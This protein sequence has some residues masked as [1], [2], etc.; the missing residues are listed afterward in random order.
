MLKKLTKIPIAVLEGYRW[1]KALAFVANGEN[2]RALA[3]LDKMVRKG[4]LFFEVDLLKAQI[5]NDEK[6]F[7]ECIVLCRTLIQ[8]MPEL[9]HYDVETTKYLIAYLKWLDFAN[10]DAANCESLTGSKDELFKEVIA[11]RLDEIRE[12]WKTNYPLRIHP[13]WKEVAV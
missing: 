3:V 11:V 13:N 5:L 2:H 6:R 12:R 7:H 10:S 4:R 8:K 9:N 1:Q